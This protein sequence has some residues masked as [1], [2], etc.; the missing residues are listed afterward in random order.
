MC[1]PARTRGLGHTADTGPVAWGTHPSAGLP[2]PSPGPAPG[3]GLAASTRVTATVLSAATVGVDARLVHVEVD[4]D[5]KLPS[6]TLVGLPDSAVRESRERVMAAVRNA[7]FQWP[8]RR[9]TVN[10][11]PADLRKE[12]S[13]FDLAIAAGVLVASGQVKADTLEDFALLGELSLDGSVRPVRGLL[14]MATGL[15]ERGVY[16]AIVPV[17]NAPEAAM[18]DGPVIYPVRSLSEAVEILEGSVRIRPCVVDAEGALRQEEAPDEHDF[19]DVRGQEHA[20]RALEVAAAGGHNVVLIG[21]PGSGKTMLARR[22]P[23]ILSAPTVQEARAVTRIH[24]VAGV[25]APGQA[26]LTRRPFRAPHHT[27]SDAG[28]IGGGSSPRPGEVSLSHH[29]VLFLDE[30]PEFQ[31]RAVEALRQPMEE[32]RVTIGRAAATLTFP[33]RFMLVASMNPCPCGYLGHPRQDCLCPPRTVERYRTRLSGPLLDRIDLHVEVPAVGFDDLA[34]GPPGE[35]SAQVRSRV[36]AARQ[37]Q[38]ERFGGENSVFCNAHMDARHVRGYCRPLPR[39]A[40]GLLRAALERLGLSAR[41]H[42]RILKV[43]RTIADLAGAERIEAAHVA[44]A[45][46]YRGLDRPVPA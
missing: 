21:P 35:P 11:A 17:A 37:V 3:T 27:I 23:S 5:R 15:G 22:M 10:L 9:V 12:G 19:A 44:E 6:F 36:E 42:D 8:R 34:E 28:L 40:A 43:A 18:A 13:A 41:A 38:Q 25:L 1:A 24:S 20:K 32:C 26:L 31:R 29:G 46:Q 14:S 30:L 45:V 33:A 2:D 39:E 4:T 7:G 16:A